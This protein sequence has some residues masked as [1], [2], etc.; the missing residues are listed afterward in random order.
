MSYSRFFRNPFGSYEKVVKDVERV[1]WSS[2]TPEEQ[3]KAIQWFLD[4]KPSDQ[5]KNSNVKTLKDSLTNGVVGK[6][7]YR[8]FNSESKMD[9]HVDNQRQIG[10]HTALPFI[11]KHLGIKR[12][13]ATLM[14]F[15]N[16]TRYIYLTPATAPAE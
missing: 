12:P 14:M 5:L 11:L 10:L 4:L 13:W 2:L 1:E 8:T 15:D 16:H 9:Y 6:F 7:L 3:E